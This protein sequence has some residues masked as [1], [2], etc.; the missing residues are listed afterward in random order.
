MSC[1]VLQHRSENKSEDNLEHK[2][3]KEVGQRICD[4]WR[5]SLTINICKGWPGQDILLFHSLL[6]IKSG[7]SKH[8]IQSLYSIILAPWKQ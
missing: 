2:H 7:L 1:K 5:K 4:P 8:F 3:R 6:S